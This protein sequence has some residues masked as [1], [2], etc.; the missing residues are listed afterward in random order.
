MLGAV[1]LRP[2][3]EIPAMTLSSRAP[4]PLSLSTVVGSLFLATLTAC[5]GGGSDSPA[6]T[7]AP[8]PPP[9]VAPTAL[10][11]TVAVGAPIVNGVLR[12]LDADGNV[13]AHDVAIDADGHYSGVE[14]TG[15]GPWRLE[16]CGY[17]GGNW[18]CIYAIA[19]AA[20]TANVTPLTTAQVTLATGAT[21][22]QIMT[23]T[24]PTAEQLASAQSQLQSSL[25]S[26]LSD[27]GLSGTV[28]FTTATFTA[29]SRTGYDRV[30]DAVSV[31]VGTDSG[32]FVQLQPRL[33]DGNIYMTPGSTT[34]TIT[35]AA[36]ANDVSLASLETLF[37]GM[38][39]AMASS[40]AC[41]GGSTALSQWLAP[42]VRMNMGG[43]EMDGPAQVAV[44]FCAFFG[45][46]GS[47]DGTPMWGSHLD[48]P[49]LGRCD[50][51]GTDPLCQV[52][53]VLH[54]TD[55]SVQR[56]GDGMAVQFHGGKWL[57]RGDTM[58][59]EIHANA[60]V[61]RSQRL[62]DGS[63]PSYMRAL[64]FD[65]AVTPGVA[66]A[67][68][69]Q[70]DAAGSP[71]TIAYYKVFS[72]DSQRMSLWRSTGLGDW[73]ASTDPSNGALS[74]QDDTW[75]P[76]PQGT[77]GDDVIRN[78]YRGGR[79]VE[80]ALFSD[81][82]CAT[83][84]TVDGKSSFMVDVQGVPPVWSALPSIDWGNLSDATAAALQA[85]GVD[86]GHTSTFDASWTGTIGYD[87]VT[88]CVNGD[89][90]DGSP[91]RLS[92]TRVH[93]GLTSATL[94]LKAPATH[95]LPGDFKMLA[96][97]GRDG[98]GMGMQSNYMSCSSSSPGQW[99]H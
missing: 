47:D 16:A 45:G 51:T 86:G 23:G 44:G 30:L 79:S 82:A 50:F 65:I 72:N 36:G 27:A 61:Q 17:A 96:F 24:A 4:S 37:Q 63:A 41:A 70:R 6:P 66:C 57:F 35:P 9:V 76:L 22:D 88:F 49:V 62:D 59:I 8:A 15:S 67:Q 28:D 80:V 46:Q 85:F 75:V 99:C 20:G 93:G 32:A 74:G 78:F 87:Q 39:A 12:V 77:Q 83:A 98:D 94:S 31:T 56:V 42:E 33:G 18:K 26:T 73:A 64:Q 2:R 38:S 34:G 60:T 54:G 13:V 97:Y 58:P 55:G 90:G 71:T 95:V 92:D 40:D 89:C 7:P 43:G 21:P 11:G 48:S 81:A 53:F 25:A 52:T 84:A 29:G 10:A 68:V 5:G 19:Q 69:L 14:L 1:R 3:L 91:G